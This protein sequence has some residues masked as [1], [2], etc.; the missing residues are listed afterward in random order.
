MHGSYAHSVQFIPEYL[1]DTAKGVIPKLGR[2]WPL[3]CVFLTSTSHRAPES[4]RGPTAAHRGERCRHTWSKRQKLRPQGLNDLKE[5]GQQQSRCGPA[6]GQREL[7]GHRPS[8]PCSRKP[9]LRR[10][11]PGWNGSGPRRATGSRPE[12]RVQRDPP[13]APPSSSKVAGSQDHWGE[14]HLVVAAL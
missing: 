14:C 4:P 13:A 5:A 6:K 8:H 1:T 10:Q 11:V 7:S 3:P 2:E 9:W 12:P